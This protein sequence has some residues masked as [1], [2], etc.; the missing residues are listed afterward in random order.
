MS[1]VLLSRV[2]GGNAL[3]TDEEAPDAAA[4]EAGVLEGEYDSVIG[5]REKC[6]GTYKE[7]VIFDDDQ[8]YV[9]YLLFYRRRY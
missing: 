6:W 2:A 3:Y 9:Q 8:V 7:Y 1:C 5:D 4:L